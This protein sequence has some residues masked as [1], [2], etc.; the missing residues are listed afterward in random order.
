MKKGIFV[1]FIICLQLNHISAQTTDIAGPAF[2]YE[3]DFKQI[4]D[5]TQDKNSDLYYQKLLIRFLNNDSSL[6]KSETLALMIGYTEQP[7]FKPLEDMEKENEIYEDNNNGAFRTALTKS[8]NYLPTHPLSLLV[9]RE[10][11]YAYTQLGKNYQKDMILDS[12]VLYQDSAKYFMDLNDKVMEAMIYSGRGRTPETPIFS[13]G[14]ADG[15]H[16]IP[17]VGFKVEKKDTQ[18]NKK[19]NFLEVINAVDGIN[20]KIFYFN[21]QHAKLKIDNDQADAMTE[22][23]NKNELNKK[24][25]KEKERKKGK[26]KLATPENPENKQ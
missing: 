18:W 16:F 11:S 8:K 20:E 6:M 25:K 3:R 17:N 14:L 15:E 10:I 24:N 12:A 7:H 13:L 4:L 22:K 9:L 5:Q 19:G 21:I 2:V 1:C 26:E 23:K